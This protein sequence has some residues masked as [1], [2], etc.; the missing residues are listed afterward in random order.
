M[1]KITFE[2]IES[3]VRFHNPLRDFAEDLH[4]LEIRK[5][6]LLGDVSVHNPYLK[7]KAKAFFGECD[8]DLVKRLIE[9]SEKT[10]F[11][12]GEKVEKSTPRFT[13]EFLAEGRLRVGEAVLFPNLFS[14]ATHHPVICLCK[15]HFLKLSEF[16][17]DLMANGFAAAQKFLKIVY[18]RD[19]SAAF[20]AVTGNYL[21]PAGASL[22]HPHFQMIIT[23]VPYS[24]HARLLDAVDAYYRK[25]ASPYFLDL[26]QEEKTGPR[27]VTRKG[28]W[29]WLA[30][31]SPI[32]N[33]EVM[34]IN[35]AEADFGD[36]TLPDLKDLCYGISKVLAF[37]ETLGHLS[38]NFAVY[39][40][41]RDRSPE[42]FRC[43][44]K[45][46]SRQN[47][48]PNYRNDDYFLQKLLQAELI[49]MPPE[50]LAARLKAFF[51]TR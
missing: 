6:P 51:L 2:S 1:S 22:V 40:V 29:H 49:I 41:K 18:E 34:A 4:R 20:T 26:V 38:F 43:L 8:P 12:C 31:F 45:I 15:A 21:F 23:P 32:G 36:L 27:Y 17:P 30:P 44:I 14:L 9:E 11:F 7:D 5:D 10:C 47:L 3:E 48:Y 39:S 46:I 28:R 19:A 35:E 16:Q 25:N 24:Y 13:S 42:S 33:N 37:Y 50:D